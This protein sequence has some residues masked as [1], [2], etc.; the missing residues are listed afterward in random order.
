VNGSC[1]T[2]GN[3]GCTGTGGTTANPTGGLVCNDGASNPVTCSPPPTATLY[4]DNPVIDVGQS[5]TLHWSST[6]AA[7]CTGQGF[8]T[9]NATSGSAS[10]GTLTTA[11]TDNYILTCSNSGGSKSAT[12]SV[13]VLAPSAT[14]SADKTRVSLG[15]AVTLTWSASGVKSCTVTGPTG[16]LASGPATS[17]SFS[18]GSPSAPQTISA[19]SVYTISC[20]TNGN[21]V[22]NSVVVNLL[23][24]FTTF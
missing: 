16:T 5:T 18:T 15:T 21:P 22:S 17:Y 12:A 11:T 24:G 8:S 9:G 13:Q 20:T 19:Q 14:I 10:T 4:A 1:T 7:S 23:P 6:N 3:G 2:C